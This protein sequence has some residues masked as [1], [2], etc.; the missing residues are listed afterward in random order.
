[1]VNIEKSFMVDIKKDDD[2]ARPS[3]TLAHPLRPSPTLSPP[4]F[5]LA[6]LSTLATL[7]YTL[8]LADSNLGGNILVVRKVWAGEQARQHRADDKLIMQI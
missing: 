8:H 3:R 6:T 1:M 4:P 5:N 2:L 7:A